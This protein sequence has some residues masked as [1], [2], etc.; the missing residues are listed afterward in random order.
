MNVGVLGKLLLRQPQTHPLATNGTSKSEAGES[1]C[2]CH[3]SVLVPCKGGTAR[4][5][6][7]DKKTLSSWA[8]KGGRPREVLKGKSW[9]KEFDES[10]H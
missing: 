6:K 1:S 9:M 2:L 4:A 5:A 8:N 10:S 3:A 7:F